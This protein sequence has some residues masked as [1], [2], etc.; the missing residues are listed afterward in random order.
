MLQTDLREIGPEVDSFILPKHAH[1]QTDK[2]PEMQG[3]VTAS[4][5][6]SQVMNLGMAVVAWGDGV[7][8]PCRL[9]LVIFQLTIFTALI[10]ESRLQ[11]TTTA[12]A[13]VVV[14]LVGRHIDEVLRTDNFFHHIT[15]VVGHGIT[16]GFSDKLAGILNG[17]GH[18]QVFVPV[19]ADRQF[20][21]P[22]PF[23]VV[24]NDAG[25]LEVVFN[26]EFFQSG[27]DCK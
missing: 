19:R 1:G 7:L 9:N 6:F 20:S 21:F 26:V 23:R 2:C 18:F 14:G 17:E 13:T 16:K 5:M 25:N 8:S 11:K 22:D 12:P 10:G 15:Q 24:L 4:I 27:P 3:M